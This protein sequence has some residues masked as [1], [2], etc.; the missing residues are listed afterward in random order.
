MFQFQLGD[1]NH[2]SLN[3]LLYIYYIKQLDLYNMLLVCKSYAYVQICFVHVYMC[4]VL[5]YIDQ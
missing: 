3:Y 4:D 5:Y 2:M 1:V